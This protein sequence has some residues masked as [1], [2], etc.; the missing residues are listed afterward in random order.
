MKSRSLWLAMILYLLLVNVALPLLAPLRMLQVLEPGEIRNLALPA[1]LALMVTG[2]GLQNVIIPRNLLQLILV[3]AVVQAI[4]VGAKHVVLDSNFREYLSHIFQ[5][6]SAYLMVGVGYRAVKLG[7]DKFWRFFSYAATVAVGISTAMT[8]NLLASSEIGRLYT[9]A[10]SLLL[11]VAYFIYSTPKL[12]IFNYLLLLLSNKRGPII[13]VLAIALADIALSTK[14]VG[15]RSVDRLFSKYLKVVFAACFV[16]VAVV[17]LVSWAGESGRESSIGR[18][19]NIT[20]GRFDLQVGGA[21]SAT[22]DEFASGRLEEINAALQAMEPIDWIFGRGAGNVLELDSDNT[23]Q[24]I[25]FSPLSL[26]MTFGLPF[27]LCLYAY[28]FWIVVAGLRSERVMN[29]Q[30]PTVRI[31][32]YYIAGAAVHT[33]F[34]YSVFIDLLTFFFIGV[35]SAV[36]AA[37]S[38]NRKVLAPL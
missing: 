29:S 8:L 21:G 13:A 20:V 2:A 17:G 11:P 27:A 12:V 37:N 36:L 26:T 16:V 34:A 5:L 32:P 28:L 10:Y 6:I 38:K 18:A 35:L 1:I 31:S 3:V 30:Y 15:K 19:I 33:F 23:V 4:L 7:S 24:N 9:P 22:L 14:H 25:H